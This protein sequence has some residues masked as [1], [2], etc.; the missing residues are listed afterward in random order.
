MYIIITIHDFFY[1]FKLIALSTFIN[2]Y[3]HFG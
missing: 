2:E 3:A 1:V